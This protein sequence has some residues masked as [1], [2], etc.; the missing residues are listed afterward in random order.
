MGIINNHIFK[1]YYI[2]NSLEV[3]YLLTSTAAAK[4]NNRSYSRIR[5]MQ[6]ELKTMVSIVIVR[7]SLS[8]H[9]TYYL[10]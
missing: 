1:T 4:E 6:T 7:S 9:K 8:S 10:D 5:T 2:A 3:S